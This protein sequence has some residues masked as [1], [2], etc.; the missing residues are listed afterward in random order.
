MAIK[1]TLKVADCLYQASP[2]QSHFVAADASHIH[3]LK[4]TSSRQSRD[5]LP[6]S[7]IFYLATD[8]NDYKGTIMVTGPRRRSGYFWR[9]NRTETSRTG[10]EHARC[11]H[12]QR[13]SLGSNTLQHCEFATLSFTVNNQIMKGLLLS[14]INNQIKKGLQART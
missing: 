6:K 11:R 13:C 9:N 8:S 3:S 5:I 2:S 7:V 14:L 4:S 10:P 1:S 12:I